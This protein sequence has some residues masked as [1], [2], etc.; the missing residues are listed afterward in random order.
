MNA[1]ELMKK[2][3]AEEGVPHEAEQAARRALQ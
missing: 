1:A 2:R 3:A